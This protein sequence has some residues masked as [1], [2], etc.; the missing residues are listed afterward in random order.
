MLAMP[1]GEEVVEGIVNDG[2]CGENINAGDE[3]LVS[4]I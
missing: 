1:G 4:Y 2:G 3:G